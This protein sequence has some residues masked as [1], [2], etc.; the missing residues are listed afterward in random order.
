MR[1]NI[2]REKYFKTLTRIGK[3]VDKTLLNF[4]KEDKCGREKRIMYEPFLKRKW[5]AQKLRANLFYLSYCTFTGRDPEE[6][7]TDKNLL[8][9]M[10][11]TELELWAEYTANWIFDNK[12]EVRENPTNRK[13]TAVSAKN[14]LAD[15]V[16]M[17]FKVGPEYI[18]PILDTCDSITKGW[19]EEFILDMSTNP[20]YLDV[21][22]QE[23]MERYRK[24]LAIPEVGPSLA[25][26]VDLAGLYSG[27]KNI[28][29]SK[30]LSRIF[31]E[32]GADL[33]ILNDLGD[34]CLN[35][36]ST[37]KVSSDQFADLK[38]GLI[39]PP[40][41]L[42]Y[43]GANEKD[44]EFIKNCVGKINFNKKDESQLVKTLFESGSY[45]LISKAL[46]KSGRKYGKEIHKLDFNNEG[47]RQLQQA[48]TIFES[49]KIYHILKNNYYDATGIDWNFERGYQEGRRNEYK[50]HL[51][52]NFK[53]LERDLI[54]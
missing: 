34:F 53:E 16:R 52:K 18:L 22:F 17:A 37:D 32:F 31:L 28:D 39:T 1:T 24:K 13:K 46:K 4:F 12:G 36:V 21:S 45:D 6:P 35:N 38:N 48:V 42:M 2:G 9:L 51:D 3:Y 49:N 7:I 50:K 25:L 27:K 41:W 54:G 29:K 33:E 10:T 14:F 47:G 20:K 44:K 40:I 30:K 43:N 26:S 8:Y 15:A 19:A 23:Y 5:G 11:S